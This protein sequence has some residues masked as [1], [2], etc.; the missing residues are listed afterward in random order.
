M[1]LTLP[2]SLDSLR[3]RHAKA[4]TNAAEKEYDFHNATHRVKM[5]AD[6]TGTSEKELERADMADI[7]AVFTHVIRLYQSYQKSTPPDK[8][9]VGG[10]SYRLVN[11][12][13]RTMPSGYF[14]DIDSYKQRIKVEPEYIAAFAYIESGMKY[15]QTNEHGSVINPLEDRAKIM[16]AHL[17]LPIFLDLNAFFLEKHNRLLPAYLVTQMA[18]AAQATRTGSNGLT[19]SQRSTQLSGRT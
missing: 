15:A 1:K 6:F 9:E 18:R 16:A 12:I 5:V 17:P 10:K 7:N 19:R 13:G 11:D 4:I 3:I 14:M 2:S 8:I